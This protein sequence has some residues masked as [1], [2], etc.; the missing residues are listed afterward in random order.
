MTRTSTRSENELLEQIYPILMEKGLKSA[1]MDCVAKQLQISKR[2]LYEIFENK[3]DMLKK[4]LECHAEKN[5]LR[6]AEILDFSSNSI[7]AFIRIFSLHRDDLLRLNIA[8]FKDMDRLY[9]GMR[10]EHDEHES[11]MNAKIQEL[12]K[13]GIEE[14]LI[15]PD[16]NFSVLL[17]MLKIQFESLKRMEELFPP[18]ITLLEIF[19]TVIL[20][21]LRG[22]ATQNGHSVI[23]NLTP[24]YFQEARPDKL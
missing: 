8:F 20:G 16:L 19:D 15:R 5:K 2:T 23:D 11:K 17:R 4:V 3:N 10:P 13:N 1:T 12:I 6:V 7:E 22:I 9:Q 21:F 24:I 18:E 14:G